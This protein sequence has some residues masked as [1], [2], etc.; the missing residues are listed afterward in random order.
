VY[1]ASFAEK[2]MISDSLPIDLQAASLYK[3]H[4]LWLQPYFENAHP[5]NSG[6]A[7]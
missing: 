1:Y 6:G 3:A 5:D 4:P 7:M 2:K